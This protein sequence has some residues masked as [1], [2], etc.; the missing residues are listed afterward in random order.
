MVEELLESTRAATRREMRAARAAL[1]AGDRLVAADA[2]ARHLAERPELRTPG[3]VAGYWAIG[4]ELPLHAVQMRLAPGQVWCLP[5]VQGD[6]TLRFA[7]WRPGDP[8]VANRFGIPEPDVASGSTLSPVELAVVLVPLVAFDASGHRLGMGGG[9]YDRTFGFRQGT[10]PPPW[11]VGVGYSLQE[12]D[13]VGGEA[14]DV[15][16]DAVATEREVRRFRG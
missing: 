15:R 1:G 14:W 2:V 5:V 16:L 7:P 12:V 9:Y 11:L 6:G 4:G 13:D 10:V 3:Y 8:T